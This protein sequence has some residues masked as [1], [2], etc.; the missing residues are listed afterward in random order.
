MT[1]DKNPSDASGEPVPTELILAG[2]TAITNNMGRIV[3]T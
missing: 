1:A 2:L 3:S